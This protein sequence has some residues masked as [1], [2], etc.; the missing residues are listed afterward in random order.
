MR[1]LNFNQFVNEGTESN[2]PEGGTHSPMAH[3]AD[4]LIS[5]GFVKLNNAN[6]NL[7]PNGE[8]NSLE[9][10]MDENG[11]FIF[12]NK[13]AQK[14]SLTVTVNDVIKVNKEYKIAPPTYLVDHNQIIKDLGIYKTYQF[15]QTP[16]RG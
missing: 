10:G 11:A 9:K 12:Y 13:D 2:L 4:E 14:I 8:F 3:L 7:G 1:L 15:K 5:F 6:I 16:D